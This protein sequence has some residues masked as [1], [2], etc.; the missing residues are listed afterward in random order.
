MEWLEDLLR[1]NPEGMKPMDVVSEG[2]I[3]G[4]SRAVVYRARKEL[5]GKIDNTIGHKAPNNCW[6]WADANELE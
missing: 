5:R 4:Y 6:K 2:N 1:A 3:E